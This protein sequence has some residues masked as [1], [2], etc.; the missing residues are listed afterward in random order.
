LHNYTV[1]NNEKLPTHIFVFRS[2]ASEGEYEKIATHELAGFHEAFQEA[3]KPGAKLPSIT[4]IVCQRASNYRVVPFNVN[5]NERPAQ[6]NCKPGTVVDKAVMHASFSEFLLVGHTA[7]QG[8]AQPVRCTVVVDN[9][10]NRIPLQQLEYITFNLCYAHGIVCSP[11]S[12]PAPLYAATELGK[13][14]RNNYKFK[15]FD[16][17]DRGSESSG[18]G[19]FQMRRPAAD[20][21]AE[22]GGPSEAELERFYMD[23]SNELE[24]N[25]DTKFWA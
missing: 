12:V 24:P 1:R 22:A 11:V 2:G 15:N 5:P 25:I 10:P 8:T 3:L 7:I 14:G 20:A 9:G 23:M 18:G 4:I 19:R 13:R 21:E 6:Q 17:E 16:G